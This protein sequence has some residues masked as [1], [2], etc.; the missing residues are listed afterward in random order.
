MANRNLTWHD[1]TANSP[2]FNDFN[3]TLSNLSLTIISFGIFLLLVIPY[4]QCTGE[5]GAN[6]GEQMNFRLCEHCKMADFPRVIAGFEGLSRLLKAHLQGN[7][8]PIDPLRQV[9][10]ISP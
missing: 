10:I 5:S 4:Q 2:F 3:D 8:R 7:R 6:R 9:N 1:F